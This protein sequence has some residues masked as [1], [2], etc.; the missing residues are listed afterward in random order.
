MLNAIRHGFANLTNFEGRDARQAFWY[1][2]LFLYL[3]TMVIGFAISIP[4]SMQGMAIGIQ[5]GMA[6]VGSSNPQAAQAAVQSAVYESMKGYMPLLLWTSLASAL[7]LLLGL[8]A[9]VVR[10]LHDSGL[11][12]YWALLPGALQAYSAAMIPSQ[13]GRIDRM[14]AASMSGAPFASIRVLR[15]SFNFS[16]IAGWLAILAVIVFGVRKSVDGPNQYGDVPFNS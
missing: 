8:V 10:R 9:S 12:G 1:W 6:Q 14:M 16:M 2:V 11:S 5:Q 3:C 15:D 7:I 13:L 4:M